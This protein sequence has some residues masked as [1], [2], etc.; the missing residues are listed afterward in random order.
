MFLFCC[1]L[2][3]FVCVVVLVGLVYVVVFLLQY[4]VIVFVWDGMWFDVISVGDMLNL[5]VLLWCGVFFIDN[6]LIYFIFIM[7]NVLSF[8]IGVFL[9]L[10]GFYGNSFY[11]LGGEGLNVKGE[12]VDFQDLIYIEDYVVLCDFD[13]YEDG[14]LL[15]VLILFV[16]VYKVGLI[17]VVIGK[18]G[19]VF[20][21]DYKFFNVGGINVLL[22]ENI[23]LLLVFVKELQSVGYKLLVYIVYIYDVCQLQLCEDNDVFIEVGKL[24]KFKDGV[25]FD[26]IVVGE[27]MFGLVNVWMMQ[28]YLDEVLFRYWL[29]VSIVWLCN[30][31]I[32]QYQ[33]G[34]GL[35]EFYFVL[36]V[37]DVLFGQLE[38][39]LCELG[40]VQDIN[41]IVVFDYGYSNVVG[42]V[43]LFL[44]CVI[45]DGCVVGIDKEW[46]FLVFGSVCMVD[47]LICVG[48]YVYDGEGCIY[49]LVM[50]GICVDGMLLYFICY[51]DDGCVCGKFGLYIMFSYVVFDV[52]LKDVVV[53][54]LNDGIDYLYVFMYDVV[55]VKCV[56]CFLQLCVVVN[57]VFV[58]KCYGVIFGIMLVEVVYLENVCCGLDII[59][60]YV[61]DVDVVVQGFFGIEVGMV[62]IECGQYGS[63]SLCDVYNMLIVSGL[64]FQCVMCDL[65]FSGNVDVVFML[66]VFLNLLLFIV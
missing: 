26:V 22:D 58:V 10:I 51:D 35:L 33:Y 25:I 11:V 24:V 43:D 56:V 27:I 17:I 18:F 44:L 42:L 4:C 54:V 23:V 12:V 38:V 28:V 30:L 14:V 39:K 66:V 60:S 48:F 13:C 20:L 1:L 40:M 3:F 59:I 52:L 62:F 15:E 7:V 61:W 37:Q 19:L 21:Q 49:V 8:V 16:M 31:D 46:G 36:Q 47:D 45:N 65:L 6:Y 64:D 34:V 2:V 9:G 41:L 55:L 50:S 29:D 5:L 53:I 63:F 32:I 57:M